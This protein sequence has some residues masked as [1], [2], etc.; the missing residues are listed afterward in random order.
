MHAL[1]KDSLLIDINLCPDLLEL[2]IYGLQK[3][4]AACALIS[5]AKDG[6]VRSI[7]SAWVTSCRGALT[8][9]T[10]AYILFA[11]LVNVSASFS[12]STESSLSSGVLSAP[13]V[14]SCDSASAG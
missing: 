1:H 4:S 7:P 2:C 9:G 13:S 10:W 8:P 11:L 14:G 3:A 6:A 12:V 5:F